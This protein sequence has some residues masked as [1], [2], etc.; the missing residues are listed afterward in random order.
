M[1]AAVLLLFT[2]VEGIK[3]SHVY[4]PVQYKGVAILCGTVVPC[5]FIL[6]SSSISVR[7]DFDR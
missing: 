1:S 4:D 2:V 3:A 5:S 7:C 6:I